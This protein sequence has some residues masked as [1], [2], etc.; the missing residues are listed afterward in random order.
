MM[1]AG[2]DLA[3]GI[4]RR[5]WAGDTSK[6]EPRH[7]ITSAFLKAS[8]AAFKAGSLKESPKLVMQS[9]R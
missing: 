5:S 2:W 8:L 9:R 4:V 3:P 7:M 6:L 1:S